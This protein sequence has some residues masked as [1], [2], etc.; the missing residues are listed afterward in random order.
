MFCLQPQLCR[1]FRL[2]AT[3][4]VLT[5][6]VM[7]VCQE[8]CVTRSYHPRRCDVTQWYVTWLVYAWH[9]SS[10]CNVTQ[11]YDMTHCW[12]VIWLHDMSH[13]SFQWNVTHKRRHDS[14]ICHVTHSSV[15]WLIHT[16]QDSFVCDAKCASKTTTAALDMG[17][18]PWR[19]VGSLNI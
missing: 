3:D 9:A 19:L 7:R 11:P 8:W 14:M 12:C 1:V 17:W 6:F 16:W 10:M 18:L 2:D 15:T 4:T 13:V 5:G